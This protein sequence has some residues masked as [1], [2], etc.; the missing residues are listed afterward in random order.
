MNSCILTFTDDTAS[1]NIRRALLP[2]FK[3]TSFNFH[4]HPVYKKDTMYLLLTDAHSV[5]A[6]HID[7]DIE[8]E[9]GKI[10]ILIFATKHQSKSG[11]HSL[12]VHTNGN[13][14]IADFG[15]SNGFLATCPVRFIHDAYLL[16]KEKNTI[17]YDVIIEA[18][19]HG[20]D[21]NVPSA[22]IEIGSD[23]SSWIRED[24]GNIIAAVLMNILPN[25][26]F[27][28]DKNIPVAI[29]IG[30][31]HHCPEFAKRIERNEAY[32]SHVCPKYACESLTEEVLHLAIERSVP[33]A[34]IILLDWKGL[35]D[36]E[37]IVPIIEKVGKERCLAVK[38]TKHY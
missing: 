19:H 30:G 20:P 28:L 5:Y 23:E 31:L 15:G 17:G 36:K 12:S 18:T 21:T 8:K 24:A 26:S 22:W 37:R 29:G 1:M 14:G 10:E 38:K 4:R 11:I 13:W 3:K 33:K 25:F 27:D 35:A 2:Y 7:K 32:I 6:E 16:L 34:T 9:L